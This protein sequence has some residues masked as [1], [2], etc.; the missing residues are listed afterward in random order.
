MTVVCQACDGSHVKI[1]HVRA[2]DTHNYTDSDEAVCSSG[3]TEL[4]S[5]VILKVISGLLS[6]A[7]II[8]FYRHIHTT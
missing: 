2:V 5:L 3:F 6:A 8:F 4:S 7:D 1:T